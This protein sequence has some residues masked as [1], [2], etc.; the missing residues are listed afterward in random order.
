MLNQSASSILIYR[1]GSLGDT[2][3]ALPVFHKIRERFPYATISLLTNRPISEKAAP[4]QAILGNDYFYN[5]IIEYPIGTRNIFILMAVLVRIRKLKVHTV[6]NI[7]AAR[8][9][10][11]TIRDRLFFKAAGVKE[12]IGF[13]NND[14]DFEPVLNK[15]TG[16][17][18][19]EA[20]RL[21]HRIKSLGK[22]DFDN[23]F[24][25]NLRLTELELKKSARLLHVFDSSTQLFAI[26]LGTK[27]QSND[28][29]K[30]NWFNL[31]RELKVVLK[32]WKL[33]I[34]GVETEAGNGDEC[35][36]IWDYQ[37]LNLCGLTSPRVSAAVLQRTKLFIGHDSGPLHLAAAVGVPCIGIF[38]ARNLPGQWYPRGKTNRIIQHKVECAGCKLQVCIVQ[39]KK[40]IMSIEV[41]EVL[42]AVKEMLN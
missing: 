6:I 22:I 26:S 24:Y 31:L 15:Q 8:S 4:V 12:L 36:K 27:L 16:L 38:S 21:A 35:L 30:N 11:S 29:E 2:I 32:G 34:V 42:E 33:I 18:D 41:G 13:P 39:K 19:W 17:Y 20:T 3:I 37:G 9:K 7:T 28:W 40:C 23:P 14:R 10:T 5:N 1:L 25:W